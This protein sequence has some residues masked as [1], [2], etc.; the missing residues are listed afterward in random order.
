MQ[1]NDWLDV[2]AS[3]TYNKVTLVTEIG[4][5]ENCKEIHKRNNFTNLKQ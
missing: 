1:G 2:I 5:S 3:K 4:Y